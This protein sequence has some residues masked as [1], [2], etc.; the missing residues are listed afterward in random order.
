ME[1][2]LWLEDFLHQDIPLAPVS[3]LSCSESADTEFILSMKGVRKLASELLRF[4]CQRR[5]TEQV[6]DLAQNW[7]HCFARLSDG[8]SG[9]ARLFS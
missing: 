2:S 7:I 3:S 4:I 9:M 5:R 8:I 1:E 6:C